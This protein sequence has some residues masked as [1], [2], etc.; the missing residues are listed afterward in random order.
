MQPYQYSEYKRELVKE[1]DKPFDILSYSDIEWEEGSSMMID[2]A[3]KD[4]IIMS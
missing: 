2:E 4:G 1:I 3:K